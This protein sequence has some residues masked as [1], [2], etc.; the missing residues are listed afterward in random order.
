MKIMMLVLA[1]MTVCLS[2]CSSFKK[3]ETN[4]EFES[5]TIAKTPQQIK[6]QKVTEEI[7]RD[8]TDAKA[9]YELGQLY[10][11]DRLYTKAEYEFNIAINF[12]PLYRDAQAAQVKVNMLLSNNVKASQLADIYISQASTKAEQALLLGRAFQNEG[13][14]DYAFTCYE[15]A[16]ALAPNSAVLNKQVGY[17]YLNNGNKARAETYLTRSIQL[18]PYQPDVSNELGKMGVI[19]EVPQLKKSSGTSIDRLFNK[20]E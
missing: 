12:K 1:I 6:Y 18:D 3:S 11:S 14:D 8:F 15:K 17:Y 16:L 5:Q 10:V 19:V 13:L 2:G 7:Q 20:S 4:E 9:H